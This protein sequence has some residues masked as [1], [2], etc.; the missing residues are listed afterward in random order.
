M[1]TRITWH[2][3]SNFQVASGGTN[4]LIDPFFDGNPVAAT[5]WDA[6]DR[7]DLVLVTH[8]HG[9]HVG[10][11]IDICK[12]TGAKLGCVVGT[13]ARLVEAGLPRELVLNGIGFN[14]GGTVECAG[15]RIT[16]TQAYHSSESGVP[17]GYIVTMPDGFTFYHA[18]DTGIFSE[19]ELWGRLYA[20]DL[21]LLPIGGV[22][23]MDPRQAALACSLLRARSVIPM[24]W[25]TFPVLEQNTTRFREQLA[26]HAPDCR[27]FNM[28]PGESLTL[29]R[30]QEGCAC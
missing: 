8:D 4:V 19:M 7:P 6:I 29:D 21:A 24:H 1:Q 10:Q 5:R 11:A 17:V 27:L 9:D 20:I 23:T 15:V 3:H 18:G 25:G 16:M 13:D 12:A 26:N 30:S 22:F 28:T 2:G 14:I